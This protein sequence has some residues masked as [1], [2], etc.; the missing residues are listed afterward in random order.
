MSDLTATLK[1]VK[2]SDGRAAPKLLPLPHARLTIPN[3]IIGLPISSIGDFA[4]SH[5]PSLT[6]VTIPTDATGRS[7]PAAQWKQKL[8]E[9]TKAE[10]E[11]LPGE[12][13]R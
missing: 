11:K 3:T 8:A 5:S 2:Q 13:P 6:D 12:P 7:D 10:A 4:F 9:F 1:T